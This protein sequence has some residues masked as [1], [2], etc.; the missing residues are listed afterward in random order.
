MGDGQTERINRT[1]INMLKTLNEIEKSRW[2][3]H[4]PKLV[5]AY[6]STINKST[7]YSLFY[8]MF[9]RSSKLPI[10]SM[11]S[12]QN[13]DRS[14][15]SY[16]K[17]VA[18][19]TKNMQQAAEIATKNAEKSRAQNKLSYDQKIHGNDIEIG[20]R[21]L[22]RNL[23]E[24]D[25][26]GK[27]RSHWEDTVHVVMKKTENIPVLDIKPLDGKNTKS[28]RVHRNIIMPCNQLPVEKVN[29]KI[30]KTS[31]NDKV[32][33]DKTQFVEDSDSD[34]DYVIVYPKVI[35]SEKTKIHHLEGENS[36]SKITLERSMDQ[37]QLIDQTDQNE[38]TPIQTMTLMILYHVDQTVSEKNEKYLHTTS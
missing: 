27:L 31:K 6:N 3:D 35:N 21:V 1:I 34:N 8:L 28:I 11:L 30:S 5:F 36:D 26:T 33:S 4:L 2:K 13:Q 7:G 19:W 18:E 25:G 22:L 23:S 10:D 15:K 17:F 14:Q 16:E 37:E 29:K 12:V 38:T 24:R 20:D 9:G 32:I